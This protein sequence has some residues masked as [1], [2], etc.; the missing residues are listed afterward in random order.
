MHSAPHLEI[1][2]RTRFQRRS[3]IPAARFAGALIALS[4]QEPRFLAVA[5]NMLKVAGLELKADEH[6]KLIRELGLDEPIRKALAQYFD[7]SMERVSGWYKRHVR[8]V[9]LAIGWREGIVVAIVIPVTIL[10]TL[11]ASWI[12][13]YTLNR[14]SLFALIFSIG[15]LVD[16][17]IVVIENIAR[18]WGMKDGRSRRSAAVDAVSEVIEISAEQIEPPPNFGAAVKREFISGMGKVGE[19]FV[20]ILDADR[21]FDVGDMAQL[22]EARQLALAWGVVPKAIG[23]THTMTETVARAC[24]VARKEGFAEKGDE[25]VV[26]A[27]VPFGKSGGTNSLRV[28][29]V[30]RPAPKSN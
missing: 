30:N 7:E 22:C 12:M 4:E 6:G 23:E 9:L 28:A 26:V 15:I 29:V 21:A 3:A 24:E 20:I 2:C 19:R 17:A 25:I 1:S 5:N 27:G 14:V 8:L 16:D 10:L 13:G 18:H 11:F